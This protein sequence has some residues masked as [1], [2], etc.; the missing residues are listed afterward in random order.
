MYVSHIVW[1]EAD[2]MSPA[3]D[4]SYLVVTGWGVD[5]VGTL[6]YTT[7]GGWNTFRDGKDV[8]HTKN[9]MNNKD[10]YIRLWASWPTVEE[11]R[12]ANETE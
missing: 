12:V 10:G 8:L 2:L 1:H 11:V 6:L 7:D 3:E 5:M 4:G 9:A